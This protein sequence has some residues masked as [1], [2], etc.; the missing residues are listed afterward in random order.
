VSVERNCIFFL[1]HKRRTLLCTS[2]YT[3]QYLT[4]FDSFSLS[5][6]PETGHARGAVPLHRKGSGRLGPVRAPHPRHDQNGRRLGRQAHIQVR[7]AP[8][9]FAQ[10]GIGQT[11]RHQVGQRRAAGPRRRRP[12]KHK[13]TTTT[14][15][16]TYLFLSA[17]VDL[18]RTNH[19]MN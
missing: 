7:Q 4:L 16:T 2:F 3:K 12:L 10:A 9:G 14:P 1:N 8:L 6:H 18:V 17:T 11:R 15:T 19:T 5:S 13:Q